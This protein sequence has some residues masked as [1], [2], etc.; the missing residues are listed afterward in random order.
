MLRTLPVRAPDELVELLSDYPNDPRLNIFNWKYYEHFRDQ[1]QVFS[2]IT[3]VSPSRFDVKVGAGGDESVE[4]GY[5]VG[6]FF[7]VL[8]VDAATGRLI[9]PQDDRLGSA[10]SAV[11][12]LS[13]SYWKKKF[14][15]DPGVLGQQI[16]VAGVPATVIGVTQRDFFGL[17]VG[18]KRELWIPVAMEPMIQSPGR[19]TSG[20]P[21]LAL[22]ARLKPGVSVA[23]AQA[24]MR[25]LDRWRVEDLVQTSENQNPVLEQIRLD[26]E[27]AAAGFSRLRDRFG[28]PLTALMVIVALLLLL[29]CIN[30]AGMTLARAVARER[31]MA[32]RISLG[33]SRLRL[34]RQVLTESL[35]ISVLGG[36]AGVFVAYVGADALLRVVASGRRLPGSPPIEIDLHLDA[37]VLLF[38][39]AVAVLTGLLFGLAPALRAMRTAPATPLR[40]AGKTTETRFGRLVGKGLVAAQV[41]LS[42]VLLTAAGLFTGH[43][44]NL[45][46]V[47]LGFERDDI[48]LITMDRSP[49]GYNGERL[50][51]L[52]R[53]LLP[54]LEAIPGVHAASMV[55]ATPISGAAASRFI[56]AEGFEERDEDRRYVSLN[57]AGPRYFE[58][59]GTP[60]IAGR[61]FE[62][63][64]QERVAIV[65]EAL[66]GHFFPAGD[67]VGKRV[68]FEGES[69][70]YEI[71]GL[72][73]DAKYLDLRK[74]PPRTIYLPALRQGRVSARNLILRTNIDAAAVTPAARSTIGEVLADIPIEKTTTLAMQMDESIVPER[75]VAALSRLFS[76]LAAML[77][78]LGL[79][80]LLSYFVTQRRNEIGVRLAIG[81]SPRALTGMVVRSQNSNVG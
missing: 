55:G 27:P 68:T 22:I 35:L 23:Q 76:Y 26:V 37:Q 60:L 12:V 39:T 50:S 53:E 8:G 81:A 24:E 52:Y 43:L 73:G 77:V 6:D 10:E 32:L 61:E 2:G 3:G 21:N 31:E 48:L 44:S 9:E 72:V 54:R 20:E 74:P 5:V 70:P 19:R 46:N 49:D 14:D 34:V 57:T 18:A 11:V 41:A 62:V 56:V 36:L 79:Y 4:G 67:P 28:K 1:N 45:R 17:Q 7:S 51:T 38:T 42:V 65:N 30:I 78:A 64:D 33:A 71:I 69:E 66:A 58:T 47:G 59:I 40:T 15:L 16:T 63:Q 80:G 29:A 25:V 75:L 13:W